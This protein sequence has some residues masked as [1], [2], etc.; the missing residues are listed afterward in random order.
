MHLPWFF[1]QDAPETRPTLH[2]Y[3]VCVG[4]ELLYLDARLNDDRATEFLEP[5]TLFEGI[6]TIAI[7]TSGTYPS[8]SRQLRT[9]S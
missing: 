1:K 4:Y 6:S 3:S 5:A 7:H 9:S 8:V 2:I